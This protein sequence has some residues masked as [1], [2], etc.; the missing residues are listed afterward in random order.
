M[1]NIIRRKKDELYKKEEENNK[2][3]NI[4]SQIEKDSE[5]MKNDKP[6]DYTKNKDFLNQAYERTLK[7]IKNNEDEINTL[8]SDI[9]SLVKAVDILKSDSG[10]T[11]IIP[12]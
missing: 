11:I 12:Q 8:K 2:L 9:S 10:G 5:E 7:S 6:D 4:L 1:E 3:Y